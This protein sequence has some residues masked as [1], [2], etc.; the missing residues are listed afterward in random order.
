MGHERSG[1]TSPNK[2]LTGFPGPPPGV[3][4]YWVQTISQTSAC[5]L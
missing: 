1:L 5:L 3:Q 4:M 2:S